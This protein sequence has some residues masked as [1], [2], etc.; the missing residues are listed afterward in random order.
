MR[1]LK[2]GTRVMF[3]RVGDKW[4]GKFG[5]VTRIDGGYIYVRPRWSKHE[6]EVYE[7]EI[8]YCYE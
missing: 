4:N 6:I 2:V 1:K 3:T 7:N 8:H 5:F